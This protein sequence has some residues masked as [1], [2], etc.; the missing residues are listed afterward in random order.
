VHQVAWK[1]LGPYNLKCRKVGRMEYLWHLLWSAAAGPAAQACLLTVPVHQFSGLGI[2]NVGCNMLAFKLRQHERLKGAASVAGRCWPAS[3]LTAPACVHALAQQVVHLKPQKPLQQQQLGQQQQQ[4]QDSNEP[5]AMETCT[6]TGSS[7][8]AAASAAAAAVAAAAAAAGSGSSDGGGPDA[9]QQD[10]PRPQGPADTAAAAGQ[11]SHSGVAPMDASNSSGATAFG[12]QQQQGLAG[13][14]EYVLK[15]E[16]QMYKIREDE[17]SFD[18]QVRL[19][20]CCCV[21]SF[22]AG[23]IARKQGLRAAHGIGREG[24]CCLPWRVVARTSRLV[25]HT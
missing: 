17:Y 5:V 22:V 24:C 20:R 15:F 21:H 12:Q 1:K 2:A 9:M 14:L 7:A 10:T 19:L 8:G 23:S 16:T 11:V 13:G 3:S 25:A 6:P 4:Q 18:V